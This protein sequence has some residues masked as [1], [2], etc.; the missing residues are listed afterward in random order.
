[1][2]VE[3]T[4][5]A[6][7]KTFVFDPK[8]CEREIAVGLDASAHLS[9]RLDVGIEIN[10]RA[11]PAHIIHRWAKTSRGERRNAAPPPADTVR[12]LWLEG[13]RVRKLHGDNDVT[14]VLGGEE[15]GGQSRVPVSG[16]GHDAGENEEYEPPDA[17]EVADRPRIAAS[18]TIR[19]VRAI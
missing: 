19:P 5:R 18:R 13:G 8:M 17:D 3:R 10:A 4:C 14:L 2:R 16:P 7:G 12:A 9:D 11:I 6:S 1:M 15:P